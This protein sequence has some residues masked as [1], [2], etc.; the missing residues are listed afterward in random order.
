MPVKSSARTV[1]WLD[2]V[3]VGWRYASNL[4]NGKARPWL[5]GKLLLSA[6][7]YAAFVET[8]HDPTHLPI[9]ENLK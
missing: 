8:C 4:G 9:G 7:L 2:H 3:W 6:G 1:A 5:V